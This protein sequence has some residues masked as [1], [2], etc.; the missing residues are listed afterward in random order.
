MT[1]QIL[2]ENING[3]ETSNHYDYLY[4]GFFLTTVHNHKE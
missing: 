1:L 2:F 4:T 3:I